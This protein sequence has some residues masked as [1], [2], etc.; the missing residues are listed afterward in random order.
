MH[1]LVTV[2]ISSNK[3]WDEI[4]DLLRLKLCNADIHTYTSWFMEI[5]QHEKESLAAYIHWFKT[6]A[7]GCNFTYDVATIRIFIKGLNDVH[8]LANHIYEKGPQ[9]L[10]GA[11]SEGEKPN[12]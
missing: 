10:N 9:M 3:S 1:T 8:S 5:Q 7:K 12:P 11:I 6:T 4:K 2:V